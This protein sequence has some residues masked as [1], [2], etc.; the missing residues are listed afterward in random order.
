MTAPPV[1]PRTMPKELPPPMRRVSREPGH[2]L[3]PRLYTWVVFLAS[4]DIIMTWVILHMG[5]A[6]VNVLAA[7]VI[8]RWG[9]VGM[10]VLKFVS[11]IAVVLIS[12]FVG[13]RRHTTGRW[14]VTAAVVISVMPVTLSF[15]LLV[16]Y[17][18]GPGSG[19]NMEMFIERDD[20][21]LGVE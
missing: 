15:G 12:E 20:P 19:A 21:V 2:V 10:I 13:R 18:H 11:I 4:M 5:G 1:D 7:S 8:E 6:E 9:L 14:L 3:Y 16:R 17:V